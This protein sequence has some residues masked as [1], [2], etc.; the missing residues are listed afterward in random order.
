[1]KKPEIA[2]T[3]NDMDIL[4]IIP[5]YKDGRLDFLK[6]SVQNDFLVKSWEMKQKSPYI[7]GSIEPGDEITY[8]SSKEDKNPVV[9]IKY[10]DSSKHDDHRFED[11]SSKVADIKKVPDIKLDPCFPLPPLPLCKVEVKDG[12][13]TTFK[14]KSNHRIIDIKNLIS[15]SFEYG[16]FDYPKFN[17]I[18]IYIAPKEFDFKDFHRTWFYYAQLWIHSTIDY[19]INGPEMSKTYLNDWESGRPHLGGQIDPTFDQ[20]NVVYKPYHDENIKENSISFYENNDYIALL[21][22]AR[23]QLT[24][25]NKVPISKK[26][27]ILAHDL[28]RQLEEGKIPSRREK[29]QRYRKFKETIIDTVKNLDLDNRKYVFLMTKFSPDMIEEVDTCP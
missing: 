1:M 3:D 5:K 24:D 9:H 12:N 14:K 23:V 17:V 15:S 29:D 16:Q 22:T 21:A 7:I 20:F 18:E 27:N 10:K 28:E 19:L 2:F 4:R 11:V 8:H 26:K 6:F 13:I 25:M